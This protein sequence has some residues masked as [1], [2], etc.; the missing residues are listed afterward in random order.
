MAVMMSFWTAIIVMLGASCIISIVEHKQN[1]AIN[2]T[3][4]ILG[5][6]VTGT[7]M[8]SLS[9]YIVDT[10]GIDGITT[11]STN[12]KMMNFYYYSN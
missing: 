11:D 7:L 4:S 3:K 5:S 8:S 9:P 12:Q 1:C 6:S 10:T 2:N